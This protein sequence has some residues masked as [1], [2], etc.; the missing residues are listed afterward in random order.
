MNQSKAIR[1][2]L[3][4]L[5]QKEEPVVKR[6]Q[7]SEEDIAVLLTETFSDDTLQSDDLALIRAVERYHGITKETE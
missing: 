6:T 7:I 4:A 1:N 5:E 2:L 3:K